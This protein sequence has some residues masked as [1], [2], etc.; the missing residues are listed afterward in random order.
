MVAA[1]IAAS[2]DYA[3]YFLS[4]I[5][6]SFWHIIWVMHLCA[7]ANAKLKL[8]SPPHPV[9]E[10]LSFAELAD[11]NNRYLWHHRDN[12]EVNRQQN[13]SN[14]SMSSNIGNYSSNNGSGVDIATSNT[15]R[16]EHHFI[17]R[18]A[19]QHQFPSGQGQSTNDSSSSSSRSGS[20]S[21]GK[22][23]PATKCLV[24]TT[25]TKAISNAAANLPG[26]SILKPIVGVD[27]NLEANLITFFHMKY[28]V[29]EL[30]F[31]IQD[32]QD[33]AVD[34]VRNLIKR[35]PN[36]DSNLFLGGQQVGV[37]PKINNMQPAY[38]AA[39][40]ELLLVSDSGISMKQDTLLDMVL[41]LGP[42]VALVHQM[43]FICDSQTNSFQSILEKVYFGTAHARA[44]LTA[45]LLQINCPSGMS[46]L[47][48]RQLLDEVGG[49]AAFGQ[50]LAEDYFMAKSF[51]DRGWRITISSQPAWQN[52]APNT[53][54][55]SSRDTASTLNNRIQRWVKL[56]FAMVAHWTLLEPFS[57]CF[58][59]G[60]LSSLSIYYLFSD[61]IQLKASMAEDVA[62]TYQ[63]VASQAAVVQSAEH[64]NNNNIDNNDLETIPYQLIQP[65]H[66]APATAAAPI[67]ASNL[68]QP[69]AF[70]LI[71]SLIWFT[72]DY[73]LLQ[74]IQPGSL[75]FSLLDF[76]KAWLYRESTAL[77][78]FLKALLQPTVTWRSRTYK[79]KWGGL[80][81]EINHDYSDRQGKL[82]P[83]HDSN[84]AQNH[85]QYVTQ[86]QLEMPPSQGDAEMTLAAVTG[87]LLD[88]QPPPS[89][90]LL[91]PLSPTPSPLAPLL[92]PPLRQ[93]QQLPLESSIRKSHIP[94]AR[95]VSSHLLEGQLFGLYSKAI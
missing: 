85:C 73:N 75:N 28:P 60:L 30:L 36:V 76:T 25:K 23:R 2:I 83:N 74:T 10:Q 17:G 70:F 38:D 27:A 33:E 61:S 51:T 66:I 82:N 64:N 22:S 67:A 44:Y 32:P 29:Y 81:E 15:S 20:S 12:L 57:E 1:T 3:L 40:Y 53:T 65:S 47:M 13:K 72:S 4:I 34:L 93:Q 56:R 49:L 87:G 86:Q 26:V 19:S 11:D 59:L 55:A 43:P 80:A 31:C 63:F 71:H 90:Q 69:A 14:D 41:H 18:D 68:L 58:L 24:T 91:L 7:H 79:L 5:I 54:S 84:L 88:S 78:I 46:A 42:Q 95:K 35:Y 89:R 37:N 94:P 48:R 45:D 9:G 52:S 8:K 16:Q 50:Y 77:F 6:I 21:N 62:S 92:P 39:K